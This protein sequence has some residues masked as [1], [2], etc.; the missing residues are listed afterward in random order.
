MKRA[1]VF[2]LLVALAF[3]VLTGCGYSPVP[4]SATKV[5]YLGTGWYQFC[6]DGKRY[7]FHEFTGY[8]NRAESIVRVPED[9]FVCK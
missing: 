4:D 3:T 2:W 5:K 9:D 6:L 8:K 7:T 1:L